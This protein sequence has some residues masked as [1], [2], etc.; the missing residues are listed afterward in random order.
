MELAKLA[1]VQDIIRK[2]KEEGEALRKKL[3]EDLA[4]KSENRDSL[5]KKKIGR[6]DD[7][8]CFCFVFLPLVFVRLLFH[9]TSNRF[10]T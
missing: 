3:D 5:L 1:K 10:V 7:L 2:Q 6:V 9:N 4:A 8:V